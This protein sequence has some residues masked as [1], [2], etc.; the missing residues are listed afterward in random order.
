MS[1]KIS[2][3]ASKKPAPKASP[4]K[5]KNMVAVKKAAALKIPKLLSPQS[6]YKKTELFRAVA[7]QTGLDKK[8]VQKVLE[9]LETVMKL[10]LSKKGPG[11][12]VL[13]GVFKMTA[14]TKPATKSRTGKNPFTGEEMV[15]KTKPARRVVKIRILKKFKA[16]IE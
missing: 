5:P 11:Q 9:A 14:V 1:K 4:L 15:F 13:P 2:K 3:I 6:P 7:E 10:H 12:F 16:E 8:E